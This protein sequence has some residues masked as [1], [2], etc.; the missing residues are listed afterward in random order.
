[1]VR[2][3]YACVEWPSAGAR[4]GAPGQA[5][6]PCSRTTNDRDEM[7][8]IPVL[9]PRCVPRRCAVGMHSR[10]AWNDACLK[11]PVIATRRC[12]AVVER[13]ALPHVA[14]TAGRGDV[15]GD[16]G[17]ADVLDAGRPADAR[18]QALAD[19]DDD[20]R[21]PGCGHR[22]DAGCRDRRRRTSAASLTATVWLSTVPAS[23]A[24]T[25]PEAV[26]SSVLAVKLSMTTAPAPLPSMRSWSALS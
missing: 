6:S 8:V 3:H 10:L 1:M 16:R 26:T 23:S 15:L 5:K 12:P 9:P 22:R 14:E 21:G 20:L 13:V 24:C 18:V 19:V 4:D 17:I 25:L 11:S 7:L 2:R